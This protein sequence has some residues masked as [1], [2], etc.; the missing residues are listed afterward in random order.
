MGMPPA[1]SE[2]LFNHLCQDGLLTFPWL[3][4]LG[5][6]TAP[7]GWDLANALSTLR[8]LDFGGHTQI[9]KI[10]TAADVMRALTR[11]SGANLRVA[12]LLHS[13]IDGEIGVTF[14]RAS[15]PT[16]DRPSRREITLAA[17]VDAAAPCRV[18][19]WTDIILAPKLHVV[20]LDPA[21]VARVGG[22]LEYHC[23]RNN[24]TYYGGDE[25]SWQR[26]TKE[27]PLAGSY[28][29]VLQHYALLDYGSHSDVVIPCTTQE[30]PDPARVLRTQVPNKVE[31]PYRTESDKG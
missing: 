20:V 30:F 23:E 28:G 22:S 2:T 29:I 7:P 17:L 8:V 18:P 14:R 25:P 21:D 3:A 13:L 6:A 9:L 10:V 31:D 5:P 27:M 19:P 12:I 16:E 11:V 4:R 1:C 15:Q 26:Y 24:H